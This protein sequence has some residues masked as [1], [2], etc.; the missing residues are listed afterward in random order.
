MKSLDNT[1][2]STTIHCGIVKSRG[3][4]SLVKLRSFTPGKS[5]AKDRQYSDAVVIRGDL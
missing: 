5:G 2:A 3:S 1:G 4:A